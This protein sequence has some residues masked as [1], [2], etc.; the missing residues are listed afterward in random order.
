[1]VTVLLKMNLSVI[2]PIVIKN[3]YLSTASCADGNHHNALKVGRAP[4][5][6]DHVNMLGETFTPS[7]KVC[8]EFRPVFGE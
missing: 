7:A 5:E 8:C 4:N 3:P 2:S 1:M 6:P